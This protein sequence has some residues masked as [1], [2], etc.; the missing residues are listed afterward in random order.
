MWLKEV[1]AKVN[2]EAI[3]FIMMCLALIFT[4]VI[5]G[6]DL[7]KSRHEHKLRNKL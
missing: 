6:S 5:V 4:A 3:S 7:V 1:D 2:K